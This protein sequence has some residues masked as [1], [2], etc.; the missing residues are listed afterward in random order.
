MDHLAVYKALSKK[1]STPSKGLLNI[2]L[3][4]FYVQVG[5]SQFKEEMDSIEFYSKEETEDG[6][7]FKGM[8]ISDFTKYFFT[9]ENGVYCGTEVIDWES[10]DHHARYGL[11]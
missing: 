9:V 11:R 8:I 2:I 3:A 10:E 4:N 7:I 6:C 5:I 1:F